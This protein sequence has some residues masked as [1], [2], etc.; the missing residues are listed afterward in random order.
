MASVSSCQM[1]LISD[2]GA[3]REYAVESSP[4]TRYTASTSSKTYEP[5]VGCN[6][7]DVVINPTATTGTKYLR[8]MSFQHW[9]DDGVPESEHRQQLNSLVSATA[10]FRASNPGATTYINW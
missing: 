5:S 8:E 4:A 6:V 2:P 1:R 10:D 9:P 7:T 3:T